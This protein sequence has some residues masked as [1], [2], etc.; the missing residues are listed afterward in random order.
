MDFDVQSDKLFYLTEKYRK[1][2]L[3]QINLALQYLPEYE[4]F[5]FKTIS[6]YQ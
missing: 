4:N 1:S 3:Q 6:V 2:V 5:D